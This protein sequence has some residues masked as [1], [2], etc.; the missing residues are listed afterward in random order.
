[1]NDKK[2]N[3]ESNFNNEE[4][5]LKKEEN[6]NINNENNQLEINE[7]P[8]LIVDS[9]NQNETINDFINADEFQK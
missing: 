1:M 8:T 9:N 5:N 2:E 6:E 7:T 3:F 4:I